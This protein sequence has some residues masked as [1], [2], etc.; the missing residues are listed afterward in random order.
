MFKLPQEIIDDMEHYANNLQGYLAGEISAAK[1]RPMRVPRGM[2]GQRKEKLFMVRVRII[3]GKAYVH[4]LEKLAHC[5]RKYGTG[6]LHVTTRQD[7]QIH[8]VKIE[9]TI[10]AIRELA[11][12]ELS[13]RGGGGNTVRNIMNCP[14]SGICPK[15]VFDTSSYS[16]ALSGYL[17]KNP[18]NYN[19]PRKFKIIFDGCPECCALSKI[20]D[21]GFVAVKKNGA[22]GFKVFSGGGMGFSSMIGFCIE[23]FIP[24]G[25]CVYVSE[26][27]IRVFDKYGERKNRHKARLR[28]L[29]ERIGKEEFMQ[30]YKEEL[31]Q[32][33]QENI[34]PLEFVSDTDELQKKSTAG[35]KDV[36]NDEGF[37][38]W[39]AENVFSHRP[40]GSGLASD[41]QSHSQS[42]RQP[43]YYY[44]HI[45]LELGDISSDTL[46]KLCGLLK[47]LN[48][49]QIRTTS[50]QN[51]IIPYIRQE[52][53]GEVYYG[54]KELGLVS[55]KA[56]SIE[57]IVSCTGAATCNLGICNSRGLAAALEAMI[58]KEGF[59]RIK[60]LS[61]LNIKISGCPNSCGQ[62][63]IGKIS[64][65]G[66]SRRFD[67]RSVPFY[68][69]LLGGKVGI[70][71][72]ALAKE[73]AFIPAKDIPNIVRDF[74]KGYI[75]DKN[76][77]EDFYAYLERRGYQEAADLAKKYE[78][79]PSYAENK[80]YYFD[81]G[82]EEEFSLAGIGPGE[83]GAGVLDMMEADLADA[84][85]SLKAAKEYFDSESL[86]L[87]TKELYRVLSF[88]SRSL[89]VA[90]GLEPK[91]DL[92]AL[93]YFKERLVS[94]GI[95]SEVF[96]DIT[97]KAWE[98]NAGSLGKGRL[99]E[100]Y[101]YAHVLLGEL[102]DAYKN[103]D[104]AFKFTPKIPAP[105]VKAEES[106]SAV[107]LNLRGVR[108]PMNYVQA[109]VYLEN[110]KIGHVIEICLDE[111]EPIQN[112]PVSLKNDG[113]EILE[114]KKVDGYYKVL[115]KKWVDS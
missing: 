101:D 77:N 62:H 82:K 33:R 72:A 36:F 76:S 93:R 8:N 73:C 65:Y 84:G 108:C 35:Q 70:D 94:G 53:L 23:E 39:R 112:V 102:K 86:G 114:I 41:S 29:V 21:L 9:D 30:R 48:K 5:A 97:E 34:K 106:A 92:E 42:H 110:V 50:Y 57:D 79:C 14:L 91:N 1:F 95:V 58:H 78:K 105:Q 43:E 55:G 40:E 59:N 60:E 24:V 32:V 54:L 109:K 16:A 83:C 13:P 104:S 49:G 18:R 68:R 115:V 103:M 100:L 20:N 74:L 28:F 44:A 88:S 113:Q 27:V 31:T 96:N 3:A 45:R 2:Y 69:M 25:D 51:I 61:E 85:Y 66:A 46:E 15:E 19:L 98:L 89:L 38:E 87:I 71:D 90:F 80:E 4:Q 22:R 67:N 64:F 81:W 99:K 10:K 47:K 75:S 107:T 12:V 56:E 111:G 11:E 7:I 17:L 6:N 37:K 52:E 63:P 26:A